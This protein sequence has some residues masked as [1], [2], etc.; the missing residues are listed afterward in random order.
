MKTEKFCA[1]TAVV[2]F[3]Y[4]GAILS[5]ASCATRDTKMEAQSSTW[6]VT[7]LSVKKIAKQ[8]D[9]DRRN[10][11]SPR[12]QSDLLEVAFTAELLGPG[13]KVPIPKAV[14]VDAR[15]QKHERVEFS[16]AFPDSINNM[17][18]GSAK[19]EAMQR[20]MVCLSPEDDGRE[21]C[22]ISTGEKLSLT[23]SFID[24]KDYARLKLSFG[25]VPPIALKITEENK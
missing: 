22:P 12:S 11:P 25:D 1:R 18:E 14:L 23:S 8:P 3:V 15:D 17:P 7:V 20:F 10:Y 4:I 16:R 9:K 21:P 2:V 24:P 6:K 5:L 19:S 13:G